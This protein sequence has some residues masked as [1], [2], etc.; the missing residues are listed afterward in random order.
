VLTG[1]VSKDSLLKHIA[2]SEGKNLLIEN[3]I[4]YRMVQPSNTIKNSARLQ[5]VVPSELRLE[6]L[7]AA[8]YSAFGGGHFGETKTYNKV[9]ERWWW[10]NVYQDVKHCCRSC[11]TCGIMRKASGTSG[12]LQP[13]KVN[14]LWD[15]IGIDIVGKLPTTAR[16]NKFV[17]VVTEYMSRYAFAFP[18]KDITSATIARKILKH[19]LL[20]HG[21]P[22]CILTDQGSNFNLALA[23]EFY[24]L[25]QIAKNTT[26]AYHPQCDGLIERFND[27]LVRTISKLQLENPND[28]DELV[29]PA[30]F[31]YNT[32]IQESTKFTPYYVIHARKPVLVI[33]RAVEGGSRNPMG[34]LS[35]YMGQIEE[36]LQDT[37]AIAKQNLDNAQV[38][39]K[40]L[41]DTRVSHAR[42]PFKEGNQ[43]WLMNK[44]PPK[45]GQSSKFHPKWLGPYTIM[46]QSSPVNY[47]IEGHLG[48]ENNIHVQR[49]KRYLTAEEVAEK[50]E[51]EEERNGNEKEQ[52]DR[53]TIKEI[54]EQIE[55]DK[56][57]N[58]QQKEQEK[59]EAKEEQ[60]ENREE[61]EK[62][63][64]Q[65]ATEEDVE[66]KE[67]E[68]QGV[69]VKDGLDKIKEILTHSNH[70]KLS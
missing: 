27:T 29:P 68:E 65:Q 53:E 40:A 56:R 19:I 12:P 62:E 70:N 37:T 32:S 11:T 38:R 46:K 17:I 20:V 14:H 63:R 13:L 44:V 3:D 23:Q 42:H 1:E 25:F 51:R 45:A 59:E 16:G 49:L 22:E 50:K 21:A 9:I 66:Q 52:E 8:H 15:L 35:H 2:I 36:Q 31:S 26:T 7:Q 28:W 58:K 33:E 10:P 41:Y 67:E 48:R 30:L 24:R 39:Q 4:L 54:P 69:E 64:E 47:I 34:S 61:V 6:V 57:E 43:V 18:V 55:M 60:Q 5:L